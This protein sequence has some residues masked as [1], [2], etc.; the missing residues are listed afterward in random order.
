MIHDTW[1]IAVLCLSVAGSEWLVRHTP[2]RHLGTALLAIIVAALFSNAGLI[3]TSS[4]E[5]GVY[6]WILGSVAPIGIF[7]M[8]LDVRLR[9]ILKAGRVLIVLFLLGSLGTSLGVLS[10][11]VLL[12]GGEALGDRFWVL[13]GMFT[14]TYTGGSVNF[15]ALALHYGVARDGGLYAGTVA[16]DNVV[17][18]L[19]MAVTIALPKWLGPAAGATPATL[20]V[21]EAPSD[22]EALDPLQLSLALGAGALALAFSEAAAGVLAG[23][24]V[25]VPSI[26][27][28]T[29]VALLLAQWPP[30]RSLAGSRAIGLFAV[31][32]FLAVIGAFCDFSALAAM[33]SLGLSLLVL[34]AVTVTVHGAV[35]FGAG[36]LLTGDWALIAVASQANVGGPTSA[37]ALARSLGR[38]ELL[39]PSILIGSFGYAIGT[40]LGFLMAGLLSRI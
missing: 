1:V 10:G 20:R 13:G 38:A 35:V 30:V 21:A 36:R 9:D 12:G 15:N 3:P 19:W 22:S 29:T 27:I 2:L 25:A 39:L 4:R 31:Y 14:G 23:A 11:I 34:A 33:G 17:T 5:T 26:L 6:D 8:L 40:Y 28:L 7:L 32:L 16:V 24:G 37:L 18:T